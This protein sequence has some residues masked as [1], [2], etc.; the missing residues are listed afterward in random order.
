M[1]KDE[2]FDEVV[3][4]QIKHDLENMLNVSPSGDFGGLNYPLVNSIVNYILFFG[5]LLNGKDDNKPIDYINKYL[6]LCMAEF[7]DEISSDILWILVRNGCSHDYFSRIGISKEIDNTKLAYIDYN[8]KIVVNSYSL[9]RAFFKSFEKFKIILSENTFNS[10]IREIKEFMDTKDKKELLNK[11]RLK[12][13][14]NQNNILYYPS[15]G[16][17]TNP[18]LNQN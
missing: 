6:Q 4:G 1:T 12:L 15:S 7:V 8:N 16:A 18:Y 9:T 17:S 10:R 5:T 13:T 2:F 14:N 3:F 11:F